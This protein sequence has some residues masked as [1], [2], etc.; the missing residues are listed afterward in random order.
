VGQNGSDDIPEEQATEQQ[1]VPSMGDDLAAAMAAEGSIYIS[2]PGM[3]GALGLS[4]Q[5]Q[6]RRIERTLAKGLRRIS[7]KTKGGFQHVNCL[8]LDLIALWLAGAQTSG[9]K[10]EFRGKIETYQEELAPVATQVFMRVVGLRTTQ[11]I[12]TE[13]PHIA[14]LAKQIDTLTDIATFLREHMQAILE[15]QGHV[16]MRLEQASSSWRRWLAPTDD[17]GS[18]GPNR[19]AHQMTHSRPC[20]RDA[21]PR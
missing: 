16:F 14:A 11:I 10:S 21:A 8:R 12:P 5:A 9:M 6:L 1:L 3:C 17:R 19:R 13:D 18:G 20:A 2:L 15:P 7:L 4:T